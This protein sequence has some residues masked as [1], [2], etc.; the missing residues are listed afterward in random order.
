MMDQ[1]CPVTTGALT[2]RQV[3][4]C[5]AYIGSARFNATEAATEA[6]YSIRAAADRGATRTTRTP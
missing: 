3:A 4:F 1:Q 5:A 6:G 2:T